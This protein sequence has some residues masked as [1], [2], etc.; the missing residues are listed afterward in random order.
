M[1]GACRS[2]TLVARALANDNAADALTEQQAVIL[3][4][5]RL[6]KRVQVR[7]SAGSGKTFLA[8]EQA[9]RL[10]DDGNRVAL[11]CYSHGLA[12]YLKRITATWKRRQQPAYVGEFHS[13]GVLWG[14]PDGPAESASTKESAQ[15]WEHHLPQQMIELA[16]GW[17]RWLNTERKYCVVVSGLVVAGT[18][19]T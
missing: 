19:Q 17:S 10:A 8:L 18:H 6:L 16:E 1:G 14:A 5:I 15:F 11:L 2:A 13:L 4:A 12:S 9:R 7:G 3:D